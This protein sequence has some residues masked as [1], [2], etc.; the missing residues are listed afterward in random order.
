MATR[1]EGKAF[2]EFSPELLAVRD[3]CRAARLKSEQAS[4]ALTAASQEALDAELE[5]RD[6]LA[7]FGL[8]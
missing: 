5:F 3:K 6:A 8:R 2:I 7:K 1:E 4:D